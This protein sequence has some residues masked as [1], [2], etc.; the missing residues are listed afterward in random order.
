MR[1]DYM[2][3]PLIHRLMSG[4]V[5]D[6][7]AQDTSDVEKQKI[8]KDTELNI[9][10]FCPSCGFNNENKFKFCPQCGENLS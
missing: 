8:S 7:D 1:E 6:L 10:S 2:K 5:I 9:F 3:L 4:E